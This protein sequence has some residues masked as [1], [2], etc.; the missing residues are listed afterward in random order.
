VNGNKRP[1]SVTI[2]AGVYIGVGAIGLASHLTE[3]GAKGALRYQAVGV[4]LVRF[5]AIL[6]GALMLRGHNWARWLALAWIAFHLVVSA[7]HAFPEFAIH[8]LFCAGIAW[9]L[10]RP[11]A[12]R[13]F[14]ARRIRRTAA[15]QK[16]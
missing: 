11:K 13:Y 9:F 8:C 15:L 16:S 3:L 2:L 6:S 14:H 12:A 1:L 4:E 10:F 7:F 5:L